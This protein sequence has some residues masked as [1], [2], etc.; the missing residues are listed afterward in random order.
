MAGQS[1]EELLAAQ[2]RLSAAALSSALA[3]Y[4]GDT[5]ETSP[6]GRP[7]AVRPRAPEG[8]VAGGHR[9]PRPFV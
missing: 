8:G 9:S 5:D 2:S 4:F 3:H 7:T 1:P 6:I